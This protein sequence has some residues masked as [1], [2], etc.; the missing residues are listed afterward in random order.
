M[1]HVEG[2]LVP[3]QGIVLGRDRVFPLARDDGERIAAESGRPYVGGATLAGVLEALEL[4]GKADRSAAQA[5]LRGLEL[6][7]DAE[8][9]EAE[10]RLADADQAAAALQVPDAM[11][12]SFAY[13]AE[14]VR[15]QMTEES[16]ITLSAGEDWLAA[17]GQS[18]MR[19]MLADVLIASAI[20]LAAGRGEVVHPG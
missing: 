9:H 17:S 16:P 11:R 1:P 5:R 19:M 12:D 20:Q 6:D 14:L 18:N 15:T 10:R 8:L 13:L 7:N 3:I 2:V 4:Y